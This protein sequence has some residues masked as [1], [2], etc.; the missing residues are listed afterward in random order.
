MAFQP[1]NHLR[2]KAN[3]LVF[4]INSYHHLCSLPKSHLKAVWMQLKLKGRSASFIFSANTTLTLSL[5]H[6]SGYSLLLLL[7]SESMT[8]L[9]IKPPTLKMA[10]LNIISLQKQNLL[11]HQELATNAS[12]MTA[13]LGS[14]SIGKYRQLLTSAGCSSSGLGVFC[15]TAWDCTGFCLSVAQ[16]GCDPAFASPRLRWGLCE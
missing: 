13:T 4:S 15:Q 11:G 12:A 7:C 5:P 14:E 8:K 10:P 16:E 1:S 3:R 6:V 9:R 2:E